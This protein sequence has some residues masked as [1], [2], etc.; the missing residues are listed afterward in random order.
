MQIFCQN[1]GE[2]FETKPDLITT[3]DFR[4]FIIPFHRSALAHFISKNDIWYQRNV[5]A[6]FK[7][8]RILPQN[9]LYLR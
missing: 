7:Q 3:V 9:E 4:L 5:H 1:I 6:V 2:L 8:P